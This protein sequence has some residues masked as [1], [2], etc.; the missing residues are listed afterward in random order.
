VRAG[1]ERAAELDAVLSRVEELAARTVIFDVEPLVAYWD[2]GED[3]LE[4]GVALIVLR[5]GQLP[6]VQVVCFATNSTR[7]PQAVPGRA[8]V[9]VVYLASAGKPMRTAPYQGF[10]R[11]GVVVGDQIATDG[12][13]ARRLGYAFV[14]YR[15]P[16]DE[17]PAGPRL[18]RQLGRLVRPVAFSRP[19]RPSR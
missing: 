17:M 4:R 15:P 19:G 14:Q 12:L 13:L 16:L 5:A 9:R 8:D 7:R 18:L 3:E 2:S 1:Y 6:E 11:P 10:P